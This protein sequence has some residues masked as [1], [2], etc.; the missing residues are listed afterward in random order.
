MGGG[1]AAAVVA[2]AA[3]A[4][5]PAEELGH[6]SAEALVLALAG[7][8]QQSAAVGGRARGRRM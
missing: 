3:V 2:A 4:A 7:V 6:E 1:T 5:A 8:Q